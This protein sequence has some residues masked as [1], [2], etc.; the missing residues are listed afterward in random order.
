MT[1]SELQLSSENV[2]NALLG[3]ADSLSLSL[4]VDA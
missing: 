3:Y 2:M 1:I 4:K